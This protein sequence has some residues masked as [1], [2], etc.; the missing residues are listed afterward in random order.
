MPPSRV[1]QVSA[2]PVLD[3][4]LDPQL[5]IAAHE[6][7]I[8][9]LLTQH[10]VVVI[11]GETGSGK[12]TQL[13]KI[14]LKLGR[15]HIGHTQP[16]RIAAHS[17]AQRIADEIGTEL[18][19][20]VGYQVR[21]SATTSEQTQLKLMTDGIL[22]AEIGHDRLLRRYDT[23]IIDEAHERSLNID[24]LLGYLKHILPQRPDLKVIITSATI[25]TASFSA[26]FD[27]APIVEVSGRTYPVEI[28]YMPTDEDQDPI[29]AIV[30][31]VASL[32]RQGDI[33]VFCSGQ[34]EIKDTDKAIHEAKLAGV[35]VL[36]L[37]ARLSMSEQARVFAPHPGQRVVLATNVAETS[38]TVPQIRYVVDPGFAR[39]SRYSARTKVQLLPIEPISQASANQR[40]GRCGRV[41]P[42]ICLRLYDEEDFLARPAYTEPEIL[43]TNLASVILSM[44]N[45][46]LG[47]I[48]DFPFVQPPD[49]SH[50]ADG[51]RLLS[52]LGAIK[53]DPVTPRLTSIGRKLA[54]LPIDPRLGRMLIEGGRQG[55]LKQTMILVAALSIPDVRERPQDHREEADRLHARFTHDLPDDGDVEGQVADTGGS[56]TVG[57]SGEVG[58]SEARPRQNR[59]TGSGS[60]GRSGRRGHIGP[61]GGSASPG[62]TAS[63]GATS[64]PARI[65]PHTGWTARPSGGSEAKSRV[66]PGGDF[67]AWLRLWEYLKRRRHELSS[68]Q[69]RRLCRAE[70][71]NYLRV[72]EWQDLVTQLREVCR[73]M[74]LPLNS[75]DPG[76]QPVLTACLAGLLSNIGALEAGSRRESGRDKRGPRQYLG[77][78]SARFSIS[79]GSSL[80]RQTPEL[81][82]A[83]ELVHTTRLWAHTVAAITP[84]QVEQVGSHMVKHTY[85]QPFFSAS[86]GTVMAHEAVSLL[87]VPL[88]ADRRVGYA[89]VDP[90]AAR[91]IFVQSGLV[92]DGFTP[93]PGTPYAAVAA[94]NTTLRRQIEDLEDKVRRRGGVADDAEIFAFF[95]AR[96]PADILSVAGLN[97]WLGENPSHVDRL[98][99]RLDDLVGRDLAVTGE[100]YPDSWSFGANS[101]G[102]DYRFAPGEDH[103]GVTVTVPLATLSSLDPAPFTWGV[104]GNRA[105]LA[106]ELIRALP[107]SVRTN[108]VPAPNWADRALAW[109]DEHGADQTQPFTSQLG[110]A[111]TALTGVTP[112]GWDPTR[113]PDHLR[114]GFAVKQRGK[115]E[116]SRDLETLQANLSAQAR[117]SLATA[118]RRARAAGTTWVFGQIPAQLTVDAHG[119]SATG[120]PCLVDQTTQVAETLATNLDQAKASHRRGLARLAG[121]GLP[122]PYKWVVAHMTNPDKI[123]LAASPYPSV[124]QLMADAR[125]AGLIDLIG[126]ADDAWQVRDQV[127]FDALVTRLRPDQ[128]T[129]T[130][131]LVV[132]AAQGLRA[133]GRVRQGLDRL[134]AEGDTA[135]DVRSQIEN[136]IFPGF[137]HVIAASWLPRLPVWL[138]GAAM[139]VEAAWSDPSRDLDRL[140]QLDPVL[141]AYADLTRTHRPS[142]E[143]EQI[144]YLI[145]ELRLQIFAQ[146]L[147]TIQTVSVKRLL[148][149]I[150]RQR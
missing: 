70:Y 31:A 125:L 45:A 26:H 56:G 16:R 89:G 102:L 138:T 2:T 36:P 127:G 35:E 116:F 149:Q 80:A 148:K 15:R 100:D 62:S 68:N 34:R 50:I 76:I 9:A 19:D 139:R 72:R 61:Q 110:R 92:E 78:R 75:A 10:Q 126:S 119:A 143:I 94:H 91:Q 12:T 128:V 59:T 131:D 118:S 49:R 51:M 20:T 77:T 147:R 85:S 144:G 22:L 146:T 123:A 103:D 135:I 37:Y 5:P 108:F 113:L 98:R 133:L 63:P 33:L 29:R 39:V 43:R 124:P 107:K 67:A 23:I 122:E 145:E 86:S 48:E 27:S 41:A 106:A 3:L 101:L 130:H 132:V 7:E 117:A 84:A 120:Y 81:V 112:T 58:H 69:F 6:A 96:L 57:P 93:R 25:D 111:L 52:E 13:P 90:V 105:E 88:V 46:R 32:P 115:T 53:D 134:D 82:M 14:C 42:G 55:C 142:F 141:D 64:S 121:F 17:V 95:D 18:G 30:A 65:T 28:R 97:H 47:P 21:F 11:A 1:G 8:A 109:L 60:R 44:A 114:M 87:G 40:A 129:R 66:D 24:F 99:M 73:Q 137:L 54:N 71:L 79:P 83:V 136:L 4:S 74:K 104:P 150:E 38:L 140:S